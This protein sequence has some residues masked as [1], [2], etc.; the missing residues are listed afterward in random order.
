[1][2][3]SGEPSSVLL[4]AGKIVPQIGK[5][6]P[7]S[8]ELLASCAKSTSEEPARTGVESVNLQTRAFQPLTVLFLQRTAPVLV[9]LH[10]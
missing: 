2:R 4:F 1:M 7:G 8:R 5:S 10:S 9:K 3:I 6:T